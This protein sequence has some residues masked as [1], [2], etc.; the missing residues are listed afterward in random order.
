MKESLLKLYSSPEA[1]GFCREL[2]KRGK[3][4][5]V[6]TTKDRILVI[7]PI[8]S[9]SAVKALKSF[10]ITHYF[11]HVQQ[12]KILIKA[13]SLCRP[14]C[15]PVHSSHGWGRPVERPHCHHLQRAAALLRVP[16]IP[17][18]LF[19]SWFLFD[20]CTEDK[21]PQEEG[22]EDELLCLTICNASHLSRFLHRKQICFYHR[23]MQEN[24]WFLSAHFLVRKSSFSSFALFKVLFSIFVRITATV[25]Q[26]VRVPVPSAPDIK[27]SLR[28]SFS[29]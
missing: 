28:I 25:P 15:D 13:R 12:A 19:W 21:G 11:V 10:G 29:T 3:F 6:A 17:Q 27:M 20:A 2:I 18:K 8:N 4:N 26:T 22:G 16:P 7:K 1:L 14:H 23:H 24:T 5:W 9:A